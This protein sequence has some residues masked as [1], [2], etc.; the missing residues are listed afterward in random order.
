MGKFVDLT[1]QR[2]G[3]LTILYRDR[4][5]EKTHRGTFWRCKC[6]CGKETTASAGNLKN[7]NTKSCGCARRNTYIKK[8]CEDL[9][10]N[11]YTNLFVESLNNTYKKEYPEKTKGLYWNCLCDC[12]NKCVVLGKYLKDGSTKSC[13]CLVKKSSRINGGFKD[14][15]GNRY[16]RLVVFQLNENYKKE[17]PEKNQNYTYWD[18]I[19]D[20]GNIITV[21][22]VN[23]ISGDVQSCGCLKSVGESIIQKLLSENNIVFE[24]EKKFPTCKYESG[25]FARFDFYINNEFLLEYDGSLHYKTNNSGWN[26]EEKLKETQKR[27]LYKNNWCLKNKIPLKRIPYWDLKNLTIEDIM[28]DKYLI[29]GE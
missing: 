14:L 21:Q 2:F 28:S 18:C 11:R 19:C 13:G 8:Y 16:N 23:L 10:G 25:Y 7:G 24:Q 26:T 20:C 29:K 5:Y 9:T 1:G 22:S 27:D 4:E 17:H 12:G 3:Q 15:T 6:E